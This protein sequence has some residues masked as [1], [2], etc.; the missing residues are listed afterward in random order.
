[1]EK[2]FAY[3]D[4]PNLLRTQLKGFTHTRHPIST[5]SHLTIQRLVTVLSVSLKCPLTHTPQRCSLPR[6]KLLPSAAVTHCGSMNVR[7]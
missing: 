3:N 5:Q 6:E 2:M 1:M 4:R 7:K